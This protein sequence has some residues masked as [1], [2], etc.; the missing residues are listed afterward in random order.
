MHRKGEPLHWRV[1]CDPKAK[2][3]YLQ[4]FVRKGVSLG[5]VG[6]NYN[7]KLKDL[8]D[9]RPD[10]ELYLE[11]GFIDYK[12]SMITDE[13]PLRGLMFCWDLVFSPFSV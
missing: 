13:D 9:K 7:L 6:R 3:L 5:R 8:K 10:L 11:R 2:M 4:S 12:T 1:K